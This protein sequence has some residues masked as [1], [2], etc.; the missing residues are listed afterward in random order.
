[1][2]TKK[3][4]PDIV[5]Q[6]VGESVAKI[7]ARDKVSGAAVFTDDLQFGPG[8]L[9]ARIKRSPYPHALIKKIDVSKAKALHGVKAIVTGQDFPGLTG[10]YLQDRSMFCTDRARYVGDP[11]AGVAAISEAIAE[12]A[13]ELIEVEYE[14][15]PPVTDAELGAQEGAP[16]IH[17]KLGDY[18]VKN[19]IFPKPGTNISNHFKIRTG[20]VDSAWEKCA[21]I[22][23]HSYRVPHIQH[24]PIEPHIAIAKMDERGK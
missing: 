13:V 16:V 6:P 10:L 17:P 1:M 2:V 4:S 12:K 23:E 19:F 22:V 8:L 9:Y 21:A 24:V 5:P 15:L 7:D 18:A 3:V 11:I 14:Q 20:D